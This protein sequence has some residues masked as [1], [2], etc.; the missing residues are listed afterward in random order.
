MK[1]AKVFGILL[2]VGMLLVSCGKMQVSSAVSQNVNEWGNRQLVPV[3]TDACTEGEVTLENPHWT[4]ERLCVTAVNN[5][6]RELRINVE[7]E[8][9]VKLEGEWYK[10][11]YLPGTV[12]G[13]TI[14]PLSPGK[15][16]PVYCYLDDDYGELPAGDYRI[17]VQ[18]IWVPEKNTEQFPGYY[19]STEPEKFRVYH[20]FTI[21]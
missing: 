1:Y 9:H 6:S 4:E 21:E 20:E 16:E 13:D 15:K 3:D 7:E 10:V 11:P 2:S 8:V 17:A 5:G 18:M 12:L 14:V 19:V